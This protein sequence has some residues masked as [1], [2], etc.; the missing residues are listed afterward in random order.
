VLVAPIIFGALSVREDCK[1]DHD[2]QRPFH[3]H[4]HLY[5]P[6]AFGSVGKALASQIQLL[7]SRLPAGTVEVDEIAL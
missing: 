6:P 2:E 7:L 4:S 1:T 5:Y 3:A